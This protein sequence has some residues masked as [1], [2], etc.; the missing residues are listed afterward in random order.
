MTII[1]LNLITG[2]IRKKI[3]KRKDNEV[4]TRMFP[5]E[6]CAFQI[7]KMSPFLLRPNQLA[8]T[9]TT[10]G[11]PVA[12]KMPQATCVQERLDLYH[13]ILTF[14]KRAFKCL[15]GMT[16]LISIFWDP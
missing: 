8:T 12:W 9:V 3:S 15:R 14:P 10:P 1:Q 7:P 13:E 2:F 6:V 5:T 4:C 16:T 11:H